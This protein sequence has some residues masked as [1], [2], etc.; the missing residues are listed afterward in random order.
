MQQSFIERLFPHPPGSR[1][2]LP[3]FED[4]YYDAALA[5]PASPMRIA[6]HDSS[7]TSSSLSPT[8]TRDASLSPSRYQRTL[9]APPLVHHNDPFLYIDRTAKTLERTFQTLLDAQSEGL[10]SGGVGAAAGDD[11]SSIGSPTPTPS[12]VATSPSSTTKP[13]TL[14][15]RQPKAKKITLR[16]ARRGLEKYMLEFAALKREEMALIEQEVASRDTALVQVSDLSNRR[17]LLEDEIQKIKSEEAPVGLRAEVQEVEQQIQQVEATLFE[18]R[19]KQRILRGQLSE[20]ES[21]RDSELSSYTESLALNERQAKSLLRRPP[22]QHSLNTNQDAGMYALKPERRTLH[23]AQE[24]WTREVEIL[25]Q[26]RSHVEDEKTALIEGSKLWRDVVQKIR[27]FEKDLKTQT[28]ELAAQ[29]VA[30]VP[31]ST[32]DGEETERTSVEKYS[33]KNVLNKLT[34]LISSLEQDLQNA[35]AKGWNLLVCAIGAELTAFEQARDLLQEGAGVSSAESHLAEE[36]PPDLHSDN[37]LVDDQASINPPSPDLLGGRLEDMLQHNGTRSP[38][39]NSNHSLEDTLREF[40]DASGKGK[41]KADDSATMLT[42]L[43]QRPAAL[44]ARSASFSPRHS[45]DHTGADA[46]RSMYSRPKLPGRKMTSESEDDE[47]GPE[48]LLSHP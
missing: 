31:S 20:M 38:G 30:D 26:R 7:I 22:V 34:N 40:G 42:G 45:P 41:Q 35:E 44:L 19:S 17:R 10:S 33:V 27:A 47:P 25:A 8:R 5:P 32:L 6:L 37:H 15:I 46:A 28:K 23:M 39:E 36:G 43:E 9:R 13:K 24:Q 4:D 16:G 18:L 14:P 3:R 48:F 1:G 11:G 2:A 29:P 12:L 21:S